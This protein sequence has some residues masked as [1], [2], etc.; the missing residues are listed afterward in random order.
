MSICAMACKIEEFTELFP[1]LS[2][3]HYTIDR[4]W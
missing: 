4:F 1:F 3:R 2:Q